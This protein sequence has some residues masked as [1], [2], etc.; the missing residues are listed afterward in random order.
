MADG[1]L[2]TGDKVNKPREALNG[3]VYPTPADM[4]QFES[5][6]V[7]VRAVLANELRAA[8]DR[9]AH[10]PA[11]LREG[12]AMSYAQLDALSDAVAYGLHRLGAR[13]HDRALFQ[14][15]NGEDLL[16]ALI[17]CWKA[18]VIPICTLPSHRE[19]EIGYL[20]NHG[21]ARFYFVQ[22]ADERFDYPAFASKMRERVPSVQHLIVAGD[23]PVK[24]AVLLGAL[25]RDGQREAHRRHVETVSAELDP[26]QP[27]VFQLSGGTT[28]VPKI[29][30]RLNFDYL[31][32]MNCVFE[33][34]RRG[35]RDVVFC[36]GPMIHNAGMV[37]HWG[38]ALLN[39]GAIVADNDLST[40][41]LRR[42]LETYRPTW[43]FV[44]RPLLGR[45]KEAMEGMEFDASGVVGVVTAS[46]AKTV[47]E[48][49]GLPGLHIFGMAEGLVMTTRGGDPEAMLDESVGRPVSPLDE[50]RLVK[51]GTTEE[52]GLGE[53]GELICR[54]PYTIR[55]Y[56]DAPE[57][58]RDA[59]TADG[60]YRSGDLLSMR[61]AENG[62]AYYV[63][64]GRLKD[65]INRAG[66][67]VNCDEVERALRGFPGLLDIA[68]VAMP[69]DV[70]IEKGCAFVCMQKGSA[71]PTV[72]AFGEFL[73]AKGLAKFKW[74]E[75]VEVIDA[76]PTTSSQK[77]SKPLLRQLIADKLRSE[78]AAA[79]R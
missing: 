77:I 12:G 46:N 56:Y 31:Y 59:F 47:R 19:A 78:Q 75:R 61:R 37:C 9:H 36:A 76:L 33:W 58:N 10:A 72:S 69:D 74:P 71:A 43:M 4:S 14:M 13:I 24:D 62:D 66:E 60:F 68:L 45:L 50:V 5:A 49:L 1:G 67:K 29:I 40:A 20:G 8:F 21:Q 70:Y 23:V 79:A 64:E 38:P 51:P 53:I 6:G 57:R 11:L 44:P 42:V 55:G 73:R 22:A 32:N 41:G 17:G 63:F 34:T 25:M 26:M 7:P 28:G 18:G 3:V 48:E 52:V 15:A 30:P 39:G 35:A 27:V 54:G 65:V 16:V 2:V